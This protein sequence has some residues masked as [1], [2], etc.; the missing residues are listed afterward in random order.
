MPTMNDQDW[1]CLL[2]KTGRE[3]LKVKE[4]VVSDGIS[5]LSN[6]FCLC[7][8]S[9]AGGRARAGRR[10]FLPPL[11]P[12][13]GFTEGTV[14]HLPCPRMAPSLKPS[15]LLI[16]AVTIIVILSSGAQGMGRQIHTPVARSLPLYPSKEIA[17]IEFL[18][19]IDKKMG[20]ANP[21]LAGSP[22]RA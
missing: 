22:V 4:Y 10:L 20:Q 15:G 5:G 14:L 3:V 8:G 6:L 17:L 1:L 21:H 7:A 11:S 19:K 9:R 2:F 12:G 13:W 16:P 18:L